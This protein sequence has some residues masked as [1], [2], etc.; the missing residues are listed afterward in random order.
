MAKDI[1]KQFEAIENEIHKS[2]YYCIVPQMTQFG[3]RMVNHILPNQTEFRN[4]T[5][6]TI[7]SLAFGIYYMGNLEIMGFNKHYPPPIRNK[8]IKGE[9]L[10]D[11]EDYD[12]AI[13]KYYCA[14][15]HTDAGYGQNTSM[16]FLKSYK[17][18]RQFEMV[19]TTG[20]EYSV[21]LENKRK[22]NVLSE[23]Y[24]YSISAFLKSFKPIKK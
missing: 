11:F 22:L 23:G 21:Y 8:L 13:R 17:S 9:E 7:T 16:D 18:T 10:F 12:G 5:G 20:T 4:L 24:E 6:N 3:I 19:F 2:M 14:K 15:I 1:T